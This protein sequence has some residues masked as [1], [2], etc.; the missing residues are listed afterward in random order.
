MQTPSEYSNDPD[1]DD[2]YQPCIVQVTNFQQLNQS[3]RKDLRHSVDEQPLLSQLDQTIKKEIKSE[4][5][6]SESED[7]TCR[8]KETVQKHMLDNE[9]ERSTTVMSVCKPSLFTKIPR[10]N[11]P[12]LIEED[13]VSED[14]IDN[15]TIENRPLQESK[16][17]IL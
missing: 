8:G 16:R 11:W 9:A 14:Q 1:E 17:Y 2:E 6:Q 5:E 13:E 3:P 15:Q 10:R 7:A 4:A 12:W